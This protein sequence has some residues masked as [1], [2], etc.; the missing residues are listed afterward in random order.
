MT[1]RYL[2]TCLVLGFMLCLAQLADAQDTTPKAS[3][4]PSG[5]EGLQVTL[6]ALATLRRPSTVSFYNKFS[7]KDT[8]LNEHGTKITNLDPT[9][10]FVFDNVDQHLGNDTNGLIFDL[11]TGQGEAKGNLFKLLKISSLRGPEINL[12]PFRFAG[13]LS[14]RLDSKDIALNFG[15]EAPAQS[16]PIKTKRGSISNWLIL[17]AGGLSS[18]QHDIPDA[19]NQVS[20]VLTFRSFVG[21]ARDWKPSRSRSMPFSLDDFLHD[22]PTLV[23]A[24]THYNALLAADATAD[25]PNLEDTM[26]LAVVNPPIPPQNQAD[27]LR[28][29]PKAFEAMRKQYAKAPSW[30]LWVEDSGWYMLTGDPQGERFKNG[31]TAERH[32]IL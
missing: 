3:A 16:L 14:G 4:S 23:A 9:H 19:K 2:L 32:V 22:Y 31:L 18:W 29:V 30:A 28:E 20:G 6:S 5:I 8:L 1:H 21:V 7:Y 24:K 27:Y 13:Q 17:G 25:L 10:Q 11:A 15:L 26:V 12:K